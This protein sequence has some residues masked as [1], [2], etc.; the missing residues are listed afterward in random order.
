MEWL[1]VKIDSNRFLFIEVFLLGS[2]VVKHMKSKNLF[3]SR[4]RSEMNYKSDNS[5]EN[6]SAYLDRLESMQSMLS[7]SEDEAQEL[8]KGLPTNAHEAGDN[9][10]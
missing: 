7:M 4:Y 3:A 2:F 1:S 10:V 8:L 9:F 6:K 5:I